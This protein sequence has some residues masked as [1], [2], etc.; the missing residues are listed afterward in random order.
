M[1]SQPFQRGDE[2]EMTPEAINQKLH[3]K[4][5]K[6]DGVVTGFSRD[7]SQVYVRRHGDLSRGRYA[8]RFWKLRNST[9]KPGDPNRRA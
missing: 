5:N 4:Q 7:G 2:V 9:E 1:T 8:V 6:R 3:G